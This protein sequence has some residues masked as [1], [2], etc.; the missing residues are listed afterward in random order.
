MSSKKA[1]KPHGDGTQII[2]E[3]GTNELVAVGI[4]N[5]DKPRLN[6][7]SRDSDTYT[8]L[9]DI[10]QELRIMNMY[11]AMITD[12]HIRREDLGFDG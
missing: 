11:N 10:L 12:V 6:V 1:H 5:P 2:G 7:E 3:N 4:T 8:L 9:G